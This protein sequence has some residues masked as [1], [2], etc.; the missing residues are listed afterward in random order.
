M[1]YFL[2]NHLR[3]LVLVTAPIFLSACGS[4]AVECGYSTAVAQVY[5][6]NITIFATDTSGKKL[7][8]YEVSYQT[9]G[10]SGSKTVTCNS[11]DECDLEFWGKGDLAITVSKVGYEST[12]AR[13]SIQ[14]VGAC[15][16]SKYSGF[17]KFAPPHDPSQTPLQ[18]PSTPPSRYERTL[19]GCWGSLFALYLI[20]V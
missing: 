3:L 1:K 15:A 18:T 10:G 4:G 16:S 2:Q 9:N 13:A 17:F 14:V 11:T 20:A 7:S 19:N 5:V 12:S 6:P 8:N